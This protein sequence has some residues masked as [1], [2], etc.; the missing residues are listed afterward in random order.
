MERKKETWLPTDRRFV[1]FLDILGFKDKVQRKEH[2]E[3]YNELKM[4]SDI[5][6]EL[7]N[8]LSKSQYGTRLKPGDIYIVNFSDSIVVFSKNDSID[9]LEVLLFSLRFIFMNSILNKI[10]IKGDIAHGVITVN[11]SL[12][13]FVGQPII[14]AYLIEEEV[15]YLG[16]VC[17]SSIDLHFSKNKLSSLVDI[18]LFEFKTPLKSG[19]I[20]H[21]NL[22]W[23]GYLADVE[24]DYEENKEA[25]KK[26]ILEEFEKLYE[27]VSGS[28]RRYV[29]NSIE[30]VLKLL[31][32]N[33]MNLY[34]I[35]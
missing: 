26:S 4:L 16:A 9:S 28:P 19:N 25:Y 23:F 18:L 7:D 33:K 8:I 14:D 6:K 13:L 34:P 10:A 29:D 15:N 1:A 30:L 3:V 11:K 35:V 21:K 2:L 27:T 20:V 17:H 31:E 5:Q 24:Y 22:D 32:N 12:N